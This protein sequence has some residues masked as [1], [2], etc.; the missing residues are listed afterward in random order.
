M[1]QG[2]VLL[3]LTAVTELEIMLFFFVC[4]FFNL[5]QILPRTLL[6]QNVTYSP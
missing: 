2:T 5:P 1:L 3:A 4:V 6:C